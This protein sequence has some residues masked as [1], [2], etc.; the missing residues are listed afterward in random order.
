M[1]S[2]TQNP[3]QFEL[4]QLAYQAKLA[5]QAG[6]WTGAR[7]AWERALALAP[8]DSPEYRTIK[9]RIENIDLQQDGSASVW[10]K[11]FYK[12]GPIGVVLWKFK[13]IAFIVLAK[14]KLLLLGLTKLS[15]LA[16][17]LLS[18]GVYCTV[19]GWK[20]GLGLVLSIYVHEMG[21][22]FW[23]RKY[24]I[25][26]T[27]PMFIPGFG[28]LIRLKSYPANP[29]QDARTGLAGPMWGLGAAVFAWAAGLLT[30]QSI[31]F[32]I[33]RTG[34]WINL[35]NLIPIWQLDGGRGFRALTRQHRGIVLTT[36]LLMW[37]ITNETMLLLIALG[38]LYRLFSKDYP[39]E[40]D[41]GVLVQFAGLIVLLSIL[42][43][44]SS[45]AMPQ[46]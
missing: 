32:A 2:S 23:L 18:L 15:T 39:E 35:F 16:S 5:A 46:L 9:T 24:G 29:G 42:F 44:L 3:V 27:A 25:E 6:D 19:Y 7:A 26:A 31:W 17:M 13:T 41:T 10:K 4:D 34:V 37:A 28:A 20:F 43:L 8:P 1:T 45:G 22:V 33:A 14:G 36:A 40:R 11:R 12:L 30:G 38:A 21:H